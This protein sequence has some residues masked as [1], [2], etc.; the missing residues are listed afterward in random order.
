MSTRPSRNS[1][2]R[3]ARGS[4]IGFHYP[5]QLGCYHFL[6]RHRHYIKETFASA[7]CQSISGGLFRLYSRID[8][9]RSACSSS[10]E[11]LLAHAGC[12]G[13]RVAS[14]FIGAALVRDDAEAESKQW[15]QVVD[16]LGPKVPSAP[17]S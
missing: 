11:R 8:G 13:R 4:A 14:A 10:T 16:Q 9:S 1:I 7:S 17:F 5:M 12:H 2:R 15:R 3:T 6:L